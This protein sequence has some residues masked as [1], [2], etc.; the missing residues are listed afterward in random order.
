MGKDKPTAFQ[1]VFSEAQMKAIVPPVIGL[2]EEALKDHI[3]ALQLE[4]GCRSTV[5]LINNKKM[6]AWFQ[7]NAGS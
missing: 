2:M 1:K 5:C 7:I 4:E 6:S 3:G